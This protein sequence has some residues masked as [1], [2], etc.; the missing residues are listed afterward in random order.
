MDPLLYGHNPAERVVAVHQL[1]DQTIRLFKRIEGKVLYEDAEFFPFFFLADSSLLNNFPKRHWLK[2]LEGTNYYKFIAAFTRWSEM[3]EAIHFILREYNKNNSP[4]ISSYQELKEI[5]VRADAARQF[6]SQSGI[7]LF[8][9]M[10]FDELIRLFIDI[11]LVSVVGRKRHKRNE[12][13][14]LVITLATNIGYEEVFSIKKQNERALLEQ[15]IHRT[16]EINPD[17]IEGFDL[18]GNIIP[19]LIRCSERQ[20]VPLSIGR[21]NSDMRIP[22]RYGT[23]GFG[24]SEWFSYEVFGRQLIDL[25]SLAETEIDTKRSGQSFSLNALA[26]HFG[27]QTSDSRTISADQI[28]EEWEKE[29]STIIDQ[30]LQNAQTIGRLSNILSPPLFHFAQM[31][32]F[33][34]RMLTQLS[35]SSRIEALL[36]REYVHQK[37]SV[38]RPSEGSRNV[39]APAEIYQTGVFSNILYAELEG[40]YSSIILHQNIKPKSDELNVF[41]SLLRSL[42]SLKQENLTHGSSDQFQQNNSTAQTHAIKLLI[43][44]FHTYLGSAKG[45]FND[46]NQ[47]EI[48]QNTGREILKEIIQQMELFNTTIIQ[49]E[50]EGFFIIPPD[51]IIG[52][53]NEQKFVER[54][55]D[56]LPQGIKLVLTNRY[57]KMF[58]YRKRNYSL[59]DQGNTVLIKGNNLISRG[60]ERYLRIFAQRFIE[61]LLTND[62][63]RLHHAYASAY[64]QVI[65]HKWT[66]Y[67]FCRAEIAHSDTETY[68]KEIANGGTNLSP[69]MEAAVQ[70][71]LFIKPNTRITYY[72][73]GNSIEVDTIHST[74]LTEEWDPN[75]PDENTSYY[76][77]RLLETAQKF[78]EFFDLTAF[79]RILSLDEMFGFS[80][81]GIR[82]LS[83]KIAPEVGETKPETEDYGIWLAETE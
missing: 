8:K 55:S 17:V 9:G 25:L 74:R 80:E 51:N 70:S 81:E 66:P 43:N 22:S 23:S 16:N 35:T 47:A 61:C 6:L 48:V 41:I 46:L 19:A 76:L 69:G 2:E 50:G 58:S 32:P 44:S 53:S 67:D 3:W 38:P 52:E 62:F 7:T 77:A 26:R 45:L 4:R 20:N 21:D 63:K 71:S 72:I 68:Q 59:L 34:F 79:E 18:F 24:E 30:S 29:P 64:T 28:H 5:L 33:P 42:S 57:K 12:E 11:Q 13:Q 36:L 56:T 10:H 82:I 49:C 1:N 40:L 73:V 31:C 54:L 37:H 78:K 60:M 15:F 39:N 27:I 75:L 14:I 65:Q 83:R